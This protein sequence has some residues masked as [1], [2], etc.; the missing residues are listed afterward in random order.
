MTPTYEVRWLV[1]KLHVATPYR[2]VAADVWE[3]ATGYNPD[4]AGDRAPMA[5]Q[6]TMA[7][8]Q[9]RRN[10]RQY[11]EIMGGQQ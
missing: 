4:L 9:H 6:V 2:D 11:A 1:N 8:I 10:R 3:R 5:R 7:L